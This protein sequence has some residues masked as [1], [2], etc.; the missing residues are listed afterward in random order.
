MKAKLIVEGTSPVDIRGQAEATLSAF[1]GP[2]RY[3]IIEISVKPLVTHPR[4][5]GPLLWRGKV[6]ATVEES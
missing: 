3:E 4:T 6:T 5:T 1:A 2:G